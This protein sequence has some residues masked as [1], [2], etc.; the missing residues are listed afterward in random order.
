VIVYGRR[1]SPQAYY[2]RLA[3]LQLGASSARVFHDGV[4]G[5]RAAGRPLQTGDPASRPRP[6]VLVRS[7][8]REARIEDVAAEVLAP[9]RVQ[10][11]DVRSHDEHIGVDV[12]AVRGGHIPGSI[13]I[14]Y[15]ANWI[16]PAAGRRPAAQHPDDSLGQSLKPRAALQD[17]YSVLDPDRPTI[18]YCHSGTRAAVTAAVLEDL[19]FRDVRVYSDS[20]LGYAARLDLPAANESFINVG[21]LLRQLDALKTRMDAVQRRGAQTAAAA[22]PS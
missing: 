22:S 9:G 12:R 17:L 20:W 7:G 10:L 4:D 19:G 18:V 2:G 1:G 15:E 6:V 3:L 11:L 21:R 5:W 8:S 14:P 16:D 13:N